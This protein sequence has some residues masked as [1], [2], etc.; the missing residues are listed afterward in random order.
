VTRAVLSI[1]SNVGDRLAYLR[2]AVRGLGDEVV[3]VSS[4]YRTAPW[5][6]ADQDDFYNAAV[7][8]EADVG[9]PGWLDRAQRLEAGAQRIRGRRWGPRTLDVD[10]IVVD[11]ETRTDERLTLP[12]PQA[13]RRAFV[14]VPIAEL[15]ED[16]MLPGVGKVRD[17]LAALPE[18]ELAGVHRLHGESLR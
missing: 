1:G 8:A 18:E 2:G 9:P 4:V 15:D 17:L 3:A 5:G 6:V 11:E 10:V 12:H 13:H 16:L 14:L 7:I